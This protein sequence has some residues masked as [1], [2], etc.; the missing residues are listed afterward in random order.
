MKGMKSAEFI[1]A[2]ENR[3]F[4]FFAGVPDSILKGLIAVLER[5]GER[6][7]LPAVREDDALGA[8]C[9]AYLAGKKPV[10]LMQNSG[11][12]TSLN[13][14]TSLHL[15]YRIPCLLLVSW[16]GFGGVD[17]PEHLVMGVACTKI[18]EQVGIP[19]R[20]LDPAGAEADLQWADETLEDQKRPVAL[21][22][23]KGVFV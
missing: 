23:K 14:L 8:A 15:I 10:V 1:Q 22:V 4:D 12:G 17:A 2:L 6:V 16:R 9:G 3:G 13:V 20:V 18:L 21:M 19:Y 11:L 5:R 7:Y